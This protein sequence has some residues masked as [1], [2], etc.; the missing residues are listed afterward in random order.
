MADISASQVK[1][2]REQTGAG[3]YDCKKALTENNGDHEAAVEW[4]RKK[5]AATAEKKASRNP[6]LRM[7]PITA[8]FIGSMYLLLWWDNKA[9]ER[10]EASWENR[11]KRGYFLGEAYSEWGTGSLD[12]TDENGTIVRVWRE[13][14]NSSDN[15][16]EYY[17]IALR[18]DGNS[19]A[20]RAISCDISESKKDLEEL[21][22]AKYSARDKQTLFFECKVKAEGGD[23]IAQDELA[24]M[25]DKGI[26]VEPDK[27][28][29][30]KWCRKSAEQGV[31]NAQLNLGIFY[32]NGEVVNQ[33]LKEAV[34]WYRKAADQGH[35]T[36][37]M[38][39]KIN[40]EKYPE[41]REN[42]SSP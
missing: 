38:L 27:S 42:P 33:D 18:F 15:G 25:Y 31:P 30:L 3:L 34:K 4:L 9:I 7:I 5:G 14:L 36:A 32:N 19:R 23:A 22:K 37:Q 10:K 39:L 26:G 24:V 12:Y 16:T 29:A 6:H 8:F 35:E 28:E 40:L 17:W 1:K 2:L 20:S 11:L 41:L 21:I 13:V